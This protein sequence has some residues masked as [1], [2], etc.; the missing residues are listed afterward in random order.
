MGG[1]AITVAT[2]YLLALNR[3]AGTVIALTPLAENM[4]SAMAVKPGDVV[5]A[6]N[7]MTIQVLTT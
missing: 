4:P 7:G 3:S 5:V 6:R 1:A 2:V